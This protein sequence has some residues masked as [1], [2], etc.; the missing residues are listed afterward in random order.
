MHHFVEWQ[1]GFRERFP[2]PRSISQGCNCAVILFEELLSRRA[3]NQSRNL[4]VVTQRVY[5]ANEA[6]EA[7][8]D[9]SIFISDIPLGEKTRGRKEF[10]QGFS[11]TAGQII[12]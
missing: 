5:E 12:F 11:R 6:H 9:F 4:G 2:Q 7:V 8:G 10:F 3:A 1:N